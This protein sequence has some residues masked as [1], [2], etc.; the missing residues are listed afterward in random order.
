[1]FTN[2]LGSCGQRGAAAV[3]ITF[4]AIDPD[5]CPIEGAVYRLRCACGRFINAI[6]GRNGCVTFSGIRPGTYELT[7]IAAPFGYELDST[8]HTVEVLRR[9]CVKIDG[10]P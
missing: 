9:G 8:I 2:L 7:Q 3:N 4:Q 6:T 5:D 10:L 1:M